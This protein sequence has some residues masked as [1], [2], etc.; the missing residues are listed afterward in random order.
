[1]DEKAARKIWDNEVCLTRVLGG[2]VRERAARK[3]VP[4][5]YLDKFEAEDARWKEF[6]GKHNLDGSLKEG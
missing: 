6:T 3:G 1:M 2:N 5:E 4:A